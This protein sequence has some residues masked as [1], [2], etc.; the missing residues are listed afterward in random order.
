MP[1]LRNF[2]IYFQLA[3]SSA[4]RTF[5]ATDQVRYEQLVADLEISES[6]IFHRECC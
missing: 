4:V 2:G 6:T 5:V 1:P 3:I